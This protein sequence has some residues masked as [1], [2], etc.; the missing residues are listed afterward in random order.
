MFLL[1][2]SF[3]ACTHRFCKTVRSSRSFTAYPMFV[4]HWCE[5]FSLVTVHAPIC[6][7]DRSSRSD[8]SH[9]YNNTLFFVLSHCIGWFASPGFCVFDSCWTDF[10][11]TTKMMLRCWSRQVRVSF[12]YCQ[13]LIFFDRFYT[14]DCG[15]RL[16]T[17]LGQYAWDQDSF[18]G[19]SSISL[20]LPFFTRYYYR[21]SGIVFNLLLI[22]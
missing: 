7:T 8:R 4:W 11:T 1:E 12:C 10:P 21:S 9:T 14:I 19:K 17:N 13:A 5:D 2:L 18:I 6:R 3:S 16:K 20:H 22:Y 15:S